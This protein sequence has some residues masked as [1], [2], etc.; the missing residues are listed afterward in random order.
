MVITPQLEGI[1]GF[2]GDFGAMRF[3]PNDHT[4]LFQL[5]KDMNMESQVQ[6][7]PSPAR[8]NTLYFLRGEVHNFPSPT[9]K[10]VN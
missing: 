2:H 1:D 4:K 3:L 9:R 6:D 5:I 8:E 10:Q 7:F